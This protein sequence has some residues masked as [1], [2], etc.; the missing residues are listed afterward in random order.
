LSARLGELDVG[1]AYPVRIVGAINVSPESFYAG[2]VDLDAEQLASRARTMA[3]DGVDL[4]DIGAMSTAPY[5]QTDISEEEERRRMQ[6]AVGVVTRAVAVPVS[7]DTQ[8]ASVAAVALAE[9]ARVINDV[10]GFAGDPRM[11]EVASVAEGVIL[12]ANERDASDDAPIDLC[13]R[14]LAESLE[15]ADRA[16]IA[17]ERVV[18]DPG[19]GFFRRGRVAWDAFDLELLNSFDRLRSLGRPLL[20]GV[21]RKSFIGKLTGRQDVDHRLAG[22]LAAAAIAVYNGAHAIRAHDV[23]ETR[24]AARVAEALRRSAIRA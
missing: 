19:V 14:L 4:I 22:S 9:G 5:L 20:V 15:R 3:D 10:S 18:L 12:M 11:A 16:G 23:A 1:D 17:R 24:D 2:S 8:R 21:S 13:L 6:W 7:A